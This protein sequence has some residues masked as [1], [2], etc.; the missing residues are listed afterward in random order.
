M[1]ERAAHLIDHVFPDVPVRQWVLSLPYRVRYL[2]A[3]DHDLC[4]AIVAVYL[5]AVLRFLRRRA[6]RD[7]IP[8]G[9]SGAVAII[10]RFGGALNLNVHIHALVL[11]GVFAEDTPDTVRF[12]PS[13]RFTR[14]DVADVV[15]AVARCIQ[16]LLDRRGL[17]GDAEQG[18][19]SDAWAE[20]APVL[21]GIAAASVQG[22]VALG[23]RAGT[24]VRRCGDPP[25]EIEPQTLGRCHAQAHGFDLHAGLV[26]QAGDRDRL[27]RLCRYAL[28]PP[29]ARDRLRVTPEGERSG[30]SCDTAGRTGRRT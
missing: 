18:G 6:Q 22:V 25:E 27:E 28:R 23:P 11:D 29:I 26:V 2:L 14:G 24:R 3:W 15:V 5:R 4:R 21:A 20:Q 19:A 1:A 10:Q 17:A 9:R 12:H 13:R 8:D 16:R 7:G 30:S